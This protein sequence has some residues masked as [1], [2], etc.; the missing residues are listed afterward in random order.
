LG[1]D[2]EAIGDSSAFTAQ[3]GIKLSMAEDLN[4]I[5]LKAFSFGKDLYKK[6]SAKS[7]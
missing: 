5:A 1:S 4:G 3:D 2:S 7:T 6:R